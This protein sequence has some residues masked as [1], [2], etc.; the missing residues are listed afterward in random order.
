MPHPLGGVHDRL[1]DVDPGGREEV[2]QDV[3]GRRP[4]VRALIDFTQRWP[5]CR[6]P[7]CTS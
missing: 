7:S 3:T 6:W 5:C 4:V 2:P 1:A